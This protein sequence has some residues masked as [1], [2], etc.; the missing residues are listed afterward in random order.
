M[1]D[2]SSGQEGAVCGQPGRERAPSVKGAYCQSCLCTI[3]C[4]DADGTQ[5]LRIYSRISL[6]HPVDDGEAQPRLRHSAWS[7]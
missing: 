6:R 2:V 3:I 4:I 1:M 5:I 7:L